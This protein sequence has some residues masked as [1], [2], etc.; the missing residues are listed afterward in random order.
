MSERCAQLQADP[1][2][3]FVLNLVAQK[4]TPEAHASLRGRVMTI[5]TASGKEAS[6]LQS[7]G[8][9]VDILG[10]TF[11]LDVPEV[12]NLWDRIVERHEVVLGE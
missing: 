8:D 11:Q 7:R 1:D 3:S 6:L 2:S 10:N 5:Q 9:L 4:R 12:A